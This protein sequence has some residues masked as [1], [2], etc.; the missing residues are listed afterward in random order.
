[1]VEYTPGEKSI[2]SGLQQLGRLRAQRH[3]NLL[4]IDERQIVFASFYTPNIAS[5]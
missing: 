5:I 2:A 4:K 1:M 3:G